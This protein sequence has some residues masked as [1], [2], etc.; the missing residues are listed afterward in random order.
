MGRIRKW[1]TFEFGAWTVHCCKYMYICRLKSHPARKSRDTRNASRSPF[2]CCVPDRLK[3]T[4]D[5]NFPPAPSVRICSPLF[6]VDTTCLPKNPHWA[7]VPFHSPIPVHCAYLRTC[8][9]QEI[10]WKVHTG[11]KPG[12]LRCS[13]EVWTHLGH[14][15]ERWFAS[16]VNK[17]GS[18]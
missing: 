18:H 2:L 11:W 10:I 1:S 3:L 4:K 12:F 5:E 14:M 17:M 13:H 15:S 7:V 16:T 8:S 6:A 9:H